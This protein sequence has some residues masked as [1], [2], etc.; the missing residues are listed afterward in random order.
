M[1]IFITFFAVLGTS[2]IIASII[3]WIWKLF[4]KKKQVEV[5]TT[6]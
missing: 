2:L 6:Q 3:L 4:T 5:E 1:N